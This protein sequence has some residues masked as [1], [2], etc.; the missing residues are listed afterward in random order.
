MGDSGPARLSTAGGSDLER[1]L[2][3]A[4]RALGINRRW[5]DAVCAAAGAA[6][7]EEYDRLLGHTVR[8]E[9]PPYELEFRTAEVFQQSQTLADIAGFY[10]AFG[11]DA[12]GPLAERADH[13]AAEWEFLAVLSIKESL[14][15]CEAE[16]ECCVEAQRAFLAEHA[17]AWMPAFFARIRKA[18]PHSFLAR[19]ADLA[20]EVLRQWCDTL[21]VSAGP[22]WLE[23]RHITDDDVTITC[24][25]PGAVELGPALAAAIEGA[26]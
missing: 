22:K 17:A 20:E 2:H 9:C 14:A 18:D 7:D 4:A 25:A 3:E 6:T 15:A 10:R 1:E 11:F 23:L 13:A 8:S 16:T 5:I 26:E 24:G 12:S 21:G 19:V